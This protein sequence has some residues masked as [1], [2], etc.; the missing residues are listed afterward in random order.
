[1]FYSLNRIVN[2]KTFALFSG[3]ALAAGLLMAA[4][5]S[6][7]FA[8]SSVEAN[9]NN[10]TVQVELDTHL[11]STA[12]LYVNASLLYTEEYDNHS[13]M[14]GTVGFQGVETDNAS[15]RA[16]VGARLYFYDYGRLSGTAVAVGGLFYHS[17][18]GAQRLS[19]GGYGWY[20]PKVTSF[21]DTEQVYELGGRLAFR[22][23]QN[24][25]IFVGYRY[26]RVKNIKY[27]NNTFDKALEKGFNVGFRL[28]F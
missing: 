14:V 12:N 9:L 15:Y 1:M 16:A 28:N 18:P 22:A 23:I 11:P 2:K 6:S 21:G 5:T 7:A 26:L 17:I 3:K 20:A 19:A 13:A 24:T 25:D 10:D 27:G 4:A 8:A